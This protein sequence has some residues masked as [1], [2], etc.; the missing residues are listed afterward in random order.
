MF[1]HN[2][3][4]QMTTDYEN[5][6]RLSAEK[7]R[8]CCSPERFS[9]ASTAEVE[10]IEGI[11][12]Q[13]R[14][15]DALKLGMAIPSPGY[16]IFV[17]GI[18]GTGRL[19]TV[20]KLLEEIHSR[21]EIISDYC[22]VHNFQ[23][24]VSPVLIPLDRGSAGRFKRD[25]EGLLQLA[26]EKIPAAFEKDGFLSARR[27]VVD[28][29]QERESEFVEAF[30]KKL[31][32]DGLLLAQVSIGPSVQNVIMVKSDADPIP[33]EKLDE[34]VKA[35]QIK[36][37]DADRLVKSAAAA[38]EKLESVTREARKIARS[39]FEEM[40]ALEVRTGE[41]VI[42][43]FIDDL[44][45]QYDNSR[46]ERFL[47]D[48]KAEILGNLG[49]FTGDDENSGAPAAHIQR[50]ERERFFRRF[51]VNVIADNGDTSDCSIVIE[52][53]PGY[54]SLFGA[55]GVERDSGGYLCDHTSI[56][57]G[58][59]LRANGGFLV[60][61][62]V[63]TLAERGVWKAL[64][65]TLRTN[66]LAIQNFEALSQTAPAILTPEP[67]PLNV[68][69][70]MIGDADTFHTLYGVDEDFQKVFKVK[71]DFRNSLDL[72]DSMIDNYASFLRKLLDEEGVLP[73]DPSGVALVVEYGVRHAGRR[74]RISTQFSEI[75]DLAREASFWA[76]E[77]GAG[78]VSAVCVQRAIDAI[79][80]RNSLPEERV[81]E[82]IDDGVVI[83]DTDG[84]QVG[85]VN[86]LTVYDMANYTF[87]T[88]A[89]I[90]V[91]VAVGKSG[92]IN[93]EREAKMSGRIHDKGVLI[94]TGFLRDRFAQDRPLTL[95]ASL[96]FEQSYSGVDGD[97]ASSTEIYAL[98]SA[99]SDLPLRQEI[100]VTGSVDQKGR[101]QPIGGVNEKVEGFFDICSRRG[102]T[103]TQGAMIPIQNVEDLMLRSDVVAAVKD[104]TFHIYAIS[105]IE[106]G[107]QILTGVAAGERDSEGDFPE[108]SV[109]A[110][111]EEKLLHLQ[112]C[113]D[114]DNGDD[115]G[116]GEGRDD[117]E[118]G[119]A[120]AP[121][122][123]GA[124][125]AEEESGGTD[126]AD[127]GD[128]A[129]GADG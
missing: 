78:V 116:N 64:K 45:E 4:D 5:R 2:G 30:K 128:G 117:R 122:G 1:L 39:L 38:R 26:V 16:N 53:T 103:G 70:I 43:G 10:P 31:E 34:L 125:P 71:A 55:I 33:V 107:I 94:L 32:A 46:V 59:L 81:G 86:G 74:T 15:L 37:E 100:A 111:V 124:E 96:C 97:S 41:Q 40:G 98:L 72:D 50:K 42:S 113:Y 120:P 19:T 75:A 108:G 84:A 105:R 93:I 6:F 99:L 77:E 54:T 44:S 91:N 89:R 80:Q 18:Q 60:I 66:E 121:A 61:N 129:D 76:G 67:I 21:C 112:K 22:Y 9:F 51:E 88:A 106:E 79:R 20:K 23:N 11:I 90:T 114:G 17:C 115:D 118:S 73:F 109:Y 101:I 8:W 69:V 63:D 56:Q 82:L 14:A 27:A 65:R 13:S 7:T 52:H 36:Q 48:L 62:A 35:G 92:I 110:R 87:G 29:H 24:P 68:K 95:S 28:A 104:G 85:Q 25:V 83:L 49:H 126:E 12:G 57:G 3:T 119:T 102:L 127:G 47:R 58:A 123:D